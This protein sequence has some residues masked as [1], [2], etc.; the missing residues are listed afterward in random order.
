MKETERLYCLHFIHLHAFPF[1]SCHLFSL[2]PSLW[3]LLS[4]PELF[5][6]LPFSGEISS[7]VL[8]SLLLSSWLAL[9]F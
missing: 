5:S 9:P 8:P 2:Q 1:T 7:R 4:S 6:L 3:L